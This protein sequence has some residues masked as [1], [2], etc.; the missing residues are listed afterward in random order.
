MT[1]RHFAATASATLVL[2]IVLMACSQSNDSD[3]TS[4]SMADP[5][6]ATASLDPGWNEFSPGG[7][8]TCADGSDY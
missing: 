1:R 2:S 8:T 5:I 6:I 7:D 4:S 3:S